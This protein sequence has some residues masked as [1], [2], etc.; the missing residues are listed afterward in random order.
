M[1]FIN[2]KIILSF[3]NLYS[4][5]NLQLQDLKQ[6]L[7][8]RNS[9]LL[10]LIYAII[11]YYEN[12]K[13]VNHYFDFDDLIKE[14]IKLCKNKILPFQELIIDEFQDTSLLRLDFIREII[15]HSDANLTVVGDDFQSIYKF[16]GCDLDIFLNFQNYFPNTKTYRIQTTYR[17]SNELIQIAGDFVMRNKAQLHKELKSNITLAHPIQIIYYF[18]PFSFNSV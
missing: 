8:E 18:N 5:H 10:F 16:S 4:A 2:K 12:Q 3:I 1:Y 6:F 17:N 14:A 15:N 9:H 11:A 13:S 7:S